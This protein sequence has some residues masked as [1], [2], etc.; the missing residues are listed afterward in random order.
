MAR[1]P[2]YKLATC[3]AWLLALGL[4]CTLA[5]Q[6]GL[7]ERTRWSVQSK[8]AAPTKTGAGAERPR[9]QLDMSNVTQADGKLVAA[10]RDGSR[11]TLTLDP[12]LQGYV[13][14]L[15]S[16]YDVPRA[17]VVAIEPT[18]GRVLA[19]VSHHAAG[20]AGADVALDAT[21]PA[22]SIFKL[23]TGAALVD[24]GIKPSRMVCYSGGMRKVT[25]EDL[26]DAAAGDLACA[27]VADAMGKSLNTVF[28]KLADRHLKPATVERYASAFGFGQTLP[29]D[30]AV[31]P[32]PY[33]I[34][35]ERLEF[36]RTCAGFW[37]VHLSP[38]H[39]ALIAATIANDGRMPYAGLT[40]RVTN[41]LG[42][43]TYEH[44]AR[45]YRDV[46]APSTARTL[47]RM[48]ALTVTHGT[49]R[50][51]FYDR[52][53]RPALGSVSVAGKTGSL[54]LAKPYES[55]TWWVGYAP[56]TNPTL[57][58][59]ALVVNGPKWRVKASYVARETLRHHF[60][61]LHK[62][63]ARRGS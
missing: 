42:E 35:T 60:A 19:H 56:L 13:S 29:F 39:A 7:A 3:V 1:R 14:G 12:R 4:G 53:G 23:V 25:A 63:H 37:H 27:N 48:M 38:V 62:S 43:V 17:A 52:H 26:E 41:S 45:T 10:L 22:A 32:S 50:G 9:A 46:I 31:S 2:R 24:A 18:T 55:Y 44:R 47:G 6:Y 34:P 49:A 57:A 51:A 16:Q 54:T 33:E 11:A 20:S 61:G 8:E 58:V 5:A 36:A 28:A 21:P 59:A 30:V 15:L 40:D